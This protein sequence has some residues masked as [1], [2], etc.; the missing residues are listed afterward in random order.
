MSPK[1]AMTLLVTLLFACYVVAGL[2]SAEAAAALG[3]PAGAAIAIG[4]MTGRR[5]RK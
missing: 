1:M 3:L 4:L 2:L 5:R